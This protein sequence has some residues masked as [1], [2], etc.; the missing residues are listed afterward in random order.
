MNKVNFEFD[1]MSMDLRFNDSISDELDE[2]VF[3]S[4]NTDDKIPGN[5]E[6]IDLI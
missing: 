6:I 4:V 3:L 5:L 1:V 2:K